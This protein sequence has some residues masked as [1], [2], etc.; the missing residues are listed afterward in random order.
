MKPS[1]LVLLL[2]VTHVAMA[3][4]D[5]NFHGYLVNPPQCVISNNETIEIPFSDMQ[6]DDI[7][8]INYMQE[9]PYT[10]DC[11]STEHDAYMTM[12]LTLMATQ[13]DFNDAAVTTDI[14]GLGIRIT[15]DDQ[16]FTIGTTLTINP[17][18]Q[19]ELKA[20]P[21]KKDGVTLPE[22]KFEAWATLQVDYQ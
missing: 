15:H 21:I 4:A 9:I 13:S 7:N 1:L 18:T 5:L 6:I 2:V 20:V 8:G 19:P 11:D 3:S 17:A 12:T 22:G 16:P 14:H 10:I